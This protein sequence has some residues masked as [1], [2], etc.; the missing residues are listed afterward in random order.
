MK[1]KTLKL[2]LHRETLV[3]L[4]RQD[5]QL[6]AGATNALLCGDDLWQTGTRCNI[7]ICICD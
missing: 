2:A 4:Q 5:V 6:V 1:K 7:S 3:T